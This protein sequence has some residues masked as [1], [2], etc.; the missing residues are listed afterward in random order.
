VIPLLLERPAPGTRVTVPAPLVPYQRI[1]SGGPVRP[2]LESN[3]A[4]AMQLR[5]QLPAALLPLKVEQA[6]LVAKINAPSRRVTVSGLP[7]DGKPVAFPPVESPLDPVAVTIT[8]EPLLRPDEEGGL[9]LELA[10]S[11][12][13]GGGQAG[14]KAPQMDEKW[15]IEYVELEVIGRTTE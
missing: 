11:D 9:H 7:A 12:T 15:T 2:V 3:Q 8:D 13:L 10:V 6:R 4:I 14:P 1:L 5:F